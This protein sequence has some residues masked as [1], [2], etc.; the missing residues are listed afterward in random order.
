[1]PTQDTEDSLVTHTESPVS[2]S[3]GTAP[4]QRSLRRDIQGLRA[5]AVL[6]VILDHL[7]GWPHAG[8]IGVDVFFVISGFVITASLVR[9]HD[10]SGKISFAGFYRRRARRILPASTLVLIATCI[11]AYVAFFSDRFRE[12]VEDAAWSL[13]FAANWR[14]AITG[15][16][17]LQA[18]GPI[19][20]LQHYWS[21]G[22]EEQFYVVWPAV[23]LLVL[24]VAAKR[25]LH[26]HSTTL[27][28]AV[29]GAIVVAS[30]AWAI[31]E[32]SERAAF[33]YF[34]TFTR[35]WELGAGA[36]LALLATYCARIPSVLRPI[37]GWS[38]LLGILVG[39]FVIQS[40]SGFPAPWAALPTVSTVVVIAA[41]T[42]GEQRL[43]SPLTNEVSQYVGNISYSLYLWHFPVIVIVASMMPTGAGY[44][45]MSLALM[46]FLSVVGYHLVEYPINHST[47]LE[48]GVD[49]P[50]DKKRV[51]FA[52]SVRSGRTPIVL[53]VIVLSVVATTWV[54]ARPPAASGG[55]PVVAA[56]P[57]VPLDASTAHRNLEL[58]GQA[59][60][61]PEGLSPSLESLGGIKFAPEDAFG[62]APSAPKG[63]ACD[64]A[65][66]DS[67]RLAVVVGDSIAVAYL[68]TIRAA[69]EPLGWHVRSLTYVG[70]PF[71]EGD[72]VNSDDSVT[73][74]CPAHKDQV[75]KLIEKYRPALVLGASQMDVTF[76]ESVPGAT[77]VDLA[78]G[79]DSMVSRIADSIGT[80][81]HLA[82]PPRGKNP[83]E[84]AT[85][86]TAPS[87]CLDV[88]PSYYQPN[89]NAQKVVLQKPGRMILETVD[90]FCTDAKVC[91]IFSGTTMVRRDDAHLTPEYA[92]AV[93]PLLAEKL[94]PVLH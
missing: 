65:G 81:V 44:Y 2:G 21:L 46:F 13:F 83:Q 45:A 74:S 19:S 54:L 34:S 50:A 4:R 6:L 59:T 31:I 57:S 68:P 86:F 56:A 73:N 42:G 62:C 12:T 30:F 33:A 28:A 82:N 70:C 36:L 87:N 80:Y 61:W 15:T 91:P 32:T 43:M 29:L 71:V 88:V 11:A 9:E 84:C 17:Y 18:D 93:A 14:F 51:A 20:P 52:P 41:G 16:D 78:N 77:R 60:Q 5:L 49:R 3:I 1:M 92:E 72:T 39:A 24:A 66:V 10:G 7:F 25:G 55:G 47:W 69:L 26:R 63:K 38:G 64:L 37:L 22:I 53:S 8:F 89:I 79:L 67:D 76:R 94:R 75:V 35:V 40:G 58:A 90:W 85:K 23:M 48:P 27:A